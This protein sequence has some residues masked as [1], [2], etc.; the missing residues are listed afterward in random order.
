MDILKSIVLI[1]IAGGVG[2]VAAWWLA[3]A[4]GLDGT[5]GA[6]IA[7]VIGMVLAVAFFAG[8]TTLLRHLGW[9]R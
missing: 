1:I 4:M 3:R 2:G 9:V 6:L 8:L 5:P 7:A